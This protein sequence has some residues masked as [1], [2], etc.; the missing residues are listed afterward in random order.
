MRVQNFAVS[1]TSVFFSCALLA[2]PVPLVDHHQHLFSP[3]ITALSNITS[4]SAEDLGGFLDD[5]GIQRAA[6]LSIA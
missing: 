1:F 5:A 3:M 4:V 2:Q 6:V